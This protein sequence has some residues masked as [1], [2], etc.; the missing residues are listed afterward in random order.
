MENV[1]YYPRVGKNYET[2]GYNGLKLLILGESHYC[3]DWGNCIKCGKLSN[4]DDCNSFTINVIDNKYFAYKKGGGEFEGWMNT[5][6]RFANVFLGDQVDNGTLIDFWD[7]VI[8]YNYVQSSTSGP[9]KS[10]THEQFL[11]SEKALNEVLQKYNPDL[12]IV[13]GNRLWDALGNGRWG[14]DYVL[15]DK[16]QRFYYFKVEEVEIPAFRIY[17]PSTSKF[18]YD[19]IKYLHEAIHLVSNKLDK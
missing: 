12:I 17:H 2:K 6:T 1:F 10:P 16:N 14:I 13:W 3:K 9:R 7:S 11:E 15:G 8:F 5:Y 4:R 19:A 18:N